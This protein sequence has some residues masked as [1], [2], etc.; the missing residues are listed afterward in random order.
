MAHWSLVR[1]VAASLIV[2]L[3]FGG[4]TAAAAT[5]LVDVLLVPSEAT[6]LSPPSSN[7]AD[8]RLGGF[9]SDLA[10][11]RT[12]DSFFGVTDRGPGGGF[13]AFAPK[14]QQFR[15]DID[16]TTGAA[17]NFRLQQTILFKTADGSATFDGRT[18]LAL[19]GD[20]S[21]L[22]LSIDPEALVIGANRHFFVA[23]EYGPSVYEFAPFSVAGVTEARFVR[24]FDVPAR[25]MPLDSLGQRNYEAERE[26]APALV[27][28]RQDNRGLEGLAISPD[29]LTLFALMQDPLAEEGL[30]NQGRR[31]RNARLIRF[32]VASGASTGEFIYQLEDIA[33]INVRIPGTAN[34]FTANQQGRQVGA[35]AIV[36]LN[37]HEFLVMER[38]TRGVNPETI[39]SG[40]VED[41]TVGTKRI[42]KIDLAGASDV[43]GVSLIG[44]NALPVGVTPVSKTLL[45][46][47]QAELVAMGREIPE[48][49]EGLAIGPQLA[50]GS[51]SVLLGTDNDFSIEEIGGTLFDVYTNRTTG[52]VGGDPLGRSLFATQIFS[53]RADLPEFTAPVPEPG[54]LTLGAAI[55]P[56]VA[57]LWTRRK[58]LSLYSR[59]SDKLTCIS[60]SS[61]ITASASS[62]SNVAQRK[63]SPRA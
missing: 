4:A 53:L 25:F 45:L 35:S 47:L 8:N 62:F 59:S 38:D 52:P 28:G 49:I 58:R 57:C 21:V 46:D 5:S 51:Y 6:D 48:R 13:N 11:D 17:S 1:A 26:T 22:G 7:P 40:D 30:G 14:I 36:A 10:Y 44:T 29:G 12:T 24:S 27:S 2:S 39:L 32:D 3:P 55:V 18:P 42:Y 9:I 31:S 37:D 41:L 20:S 54:G 56:L 43:S 15:L 33:D 19:N 60:R 61:S 16:P 34:D 50:D 23:D 63:D